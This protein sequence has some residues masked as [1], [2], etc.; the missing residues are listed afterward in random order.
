LRA[1]QL[2]PG[3]PVSGQLAQRFRDLLRSQAV[4]GFPQPTHLREDTIPPSSPKPEPGCYTASPVTPS[5]S[6]PP[7]GQFGYHPS[8]STAAQR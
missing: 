8:S 7:T 5:S 2:R 1:A 6:E 4:P 3:A